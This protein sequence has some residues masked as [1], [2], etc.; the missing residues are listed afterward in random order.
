MNSGKIKDLS[1][2]KQVGAKRQKKRALD[3]VGISEHDLTVQ[4]EDYLNAMGIVFYRIPDALYRS[5]F[6][7]RS[8]SSF[9]KTLIARFVKGVP[10]FTILS[11]DGRYLCVELKTSIGKLTQGQKSFAKKIPVEVIRDFDSFVNLVSGFLAR[12]ADK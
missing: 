1:K 11:D 12:K 9:V 2:S 4:C 7:S 6:A 10:D 3:A 8:V 5:V